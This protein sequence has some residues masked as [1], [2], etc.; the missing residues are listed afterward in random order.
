MYIHFYGYESPTGSIEILV[1]KLK[2][3]R[4]VSGSSTPLTT[5]QEE[6][7]ISNNFLMEIQKQVSSSLINNAEKT[8]QNS[9]NA[10]NPKQD[11]SGI[12]L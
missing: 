7:M 6:S 3:M 5:S 4:T 8:L 2:H 1:L 11:I 12:V 9:Q 10:Y